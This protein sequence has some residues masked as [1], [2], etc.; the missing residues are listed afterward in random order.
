MQSR[1]NRISTLPI[2]GPPS[3]NYA[4]EFGELNLDEDMDYRVCYN[5]DNNS[6]WKRHTM[7]NRSL[8]YT[9]RY[10]HNSRASVNRPYPSPCSSSAPS[11]CRNTNCQENNLPKINGKKFNSKDSKGNIMLCQIYNSCFH[12]Q[13]RCL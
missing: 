7:L 10:L 6:K 3:A 8:S 9:P 2:V 1:A 13:Y 12:L 5:R 4:Q 11:Y